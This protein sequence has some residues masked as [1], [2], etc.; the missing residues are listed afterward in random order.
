M[1]LKDQKETWEGFVKLGIIVGGVVILIL[2]LMVIF[3]V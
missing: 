1:D 2:I 3:L